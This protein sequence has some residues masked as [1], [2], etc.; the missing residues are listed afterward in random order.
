MAY[1]IVMS[2][3]DD[4]TRYFSVLEA[5]EGMSLRETINHMNDGLLVENVLFWMI[6]QLKMPHLLPAFTTSVVYGVGAYIT[7][8]LVKN[9]VYRYSWI[10]LIIQ[11]V[12]I[13]FST[14]ANN[15]RHVFAFS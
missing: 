15:I 8:D 4:M 11:F 2:H 10:I 9:G 7:F 3:T 12:M 14:V 6:A 5:L 13:P 1:S